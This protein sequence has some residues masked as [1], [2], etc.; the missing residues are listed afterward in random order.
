VSTLVL[1]RHAQASFGKSDYDKL[2][3]LGETQS[4]ML[5]GYWVNTGATFDRVL[6]GPRL[7]HR[8][9][10]DNVARIFG[11]AGLA[12]PEPE[13]TPA[14]D[15]YQGEELL[16]RALPRLLENDEHLQTL[17]AGFAEAEADPAKHRKH[18]QKLFEHMMR[19]WVRGEIDEPGVESWAAFRKRIA[20]WVREIRASAGRGK[21][22]VA[23]TSGGAIAATVAEALK[24]G[25][26]ETMELS[27]M[28]NNASLTEF[29]FREDR[30]TL[31]RFNALPHLEYKR[32]I[33]YR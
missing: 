23:F 6:L 24:M 11:D 8:Q 2:S 15:E 25:D 16:K 22:I 30:F 14:L 10:L 13:H 5:G 20:D 26:V 27:W 29:I 18:F 33:T 12:W 9:T 32:L 7:R 1:V 3:S 4:S 19:A 28:L 21:R 31:S 17:A